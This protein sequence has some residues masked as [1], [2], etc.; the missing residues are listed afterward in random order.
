MNFSSNDEAVAKS[1]VS[2]SYH[3]YVVDVVNISIPLLPCLV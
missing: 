2:M 1:F 3:S